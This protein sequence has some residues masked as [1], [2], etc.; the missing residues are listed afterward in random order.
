MREADR[1]FQIIQILRRRRVVTAA[2]LADSRN[3]S[4]RTIDREIRDLITSGVPIDGEAGVGY[5][6][7]GGF[8]LPPLM[9]DKDE[10]EVL[11]LAILMWLWIEECVFCVLMCFLTMN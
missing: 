5:A 9:F 6:L 11:V 2:N 4:Q 10:I 3:V 7:S 1:L 8:D